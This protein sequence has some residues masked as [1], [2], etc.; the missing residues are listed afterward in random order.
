M[1]FDRQ[2]SNA[3]II[4]ILGAR[5]QFIKAAVVSQAL[6]ESF[7]EIIVHTGQHYDEEL[8][9]IFFS[10]LNIPPALY[11]LNVG[12][13]SHGQ[14]TAEMIAGVEEILRKHNA[15][16]V[17]LYGDT[18]STLAGALAASKFSL[19]VVHIEAGVRSFNRDMP[20]EINRIVTD[21]V[22]DIHFAPSETALDNLAA[23]GLT[24]NVYNVGDVMYDSLLQAR[25]QASSKI[26][27]L[28][29]LD[30]NINDFI[31]CT[32]HRA[33]NTDSPKRLKTIIEGL[34]NAPHPIILPAHPRTV[35][36][37]EKYSL[38]ELVNDNIFI[39]EPVG[40]HDFVSLIDEAVMVATDSGGVQKEAFY[41]DTPCVTLRDETEWP[42]TV[43]AGWNILV[44]ADSKKITAA[45]NR[46][47]APASKSEIYGD[48][49]AVEKIVN[50]LNKMAE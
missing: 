28:I 35:D 15:N 36:R 32:V 13:G 10:E 8:S 26:L 20:E 17:L 39:I 50:V 24:D 49:T 4:T 5:P 7:E 40:Y 33:A 42:E 1:S 31:L 41:L 19:K 11:T 2:N 12:S 21:H 6:K 44:G 29:G 38:L 25:Q 3:D 14:Q 45:L 48:G 27:S 46:S 23:E 47:D 43:M 18:N 16:F 30:E 34:A 9:D 37:L 22:S